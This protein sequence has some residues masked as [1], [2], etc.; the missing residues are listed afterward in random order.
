MSP[1]ISSHFE[2]SIKQQELPYND[3]APIFVMRHCDSRMWV[4]DE[5]Y[6][7]RKHIKRPY[8]PVPANIG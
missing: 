4:L 7:W 1:I 2:S 8:I 5:R 3:A 6:E